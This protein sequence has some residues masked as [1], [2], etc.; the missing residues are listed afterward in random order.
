MATTGTRGRSRLERLPSEL[1]DI[2]AEYLDLPALCNLRLCRKAFSTG[3][4]S[5]RFQS[6]FKDLHTHLTFPSLD[7]LREIAEDPVLGSAVQSLTVL[8]VVFDAAPLSRMLQTKRRRHH[9]N[10]PKSGY[11]IKELPAT[12]DELEEARLGLKLILTE[13]Q[14]QREMSFD[15]SDLQILTRTLK[16]LGTLKILKIEGAVA[17]GG[18]F[19]DTPY[20]GREWHPM[21]IAL[22]CLP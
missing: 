3:R 19:F 20:S 5:L 11:D 21:S 15:K 22:S 8:A 2:I 13:E 17:Q 4:Y 18:G 1:A 7:Q 12:E 10:N 14:D 9:E 16:A 6:F